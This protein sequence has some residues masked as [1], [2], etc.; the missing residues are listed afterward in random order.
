[1][2]LPHFR[3]LGTGKPVDARLSAVLYGEPDGLFR[4]LPT[5][6]AEVLGVRGSLRDALEHVNDALSR[7]TDEAPWAIGDAWRVLGDIH[8]SMGEAELALAAY[9]K[10]Y[11]VGWDP[12]PGHAMLLLERGEAEAAFVSL[13]RSLIGQSW[14]TLQRQGMLLAHLALVA[15]HT[16][17][18]ERAQALIDDLAGQAARWPTPSIRALTNEASSLLAQKR[19]DRQAALRHL[20]LAR[21]LW[22]SIESQCHAARLRL[23]IAALQ[24]ELGD[25]RG[26][27]S[28]IRAVTAIVGELDSGKLRRACSELQEQLAE[29]EG[30]GSMSGADAR[31]ETL[32]RT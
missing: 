1:M 19:G 21:Q 23:A 8:A 31:N 4:V 20:H 28:E 10:A 14:W 15:A 9:E 29:Q 11:S 22:T 2:G 13:E 16:G 25:W 6:R 27:A 32:R 17:R 24:L 3:R 5:H 12:E 30:N 7:L 26:A 18:L